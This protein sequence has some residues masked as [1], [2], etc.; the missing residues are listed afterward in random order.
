MPSYYIRDGEGNLQ[1]VESE[2]LAS[3]Q[4]LPQSV[5]S[6]ATGNPLFTSTNPGNVNPLSPIPDSRLAA[7]DQITTSDV[8]SSTALGQNGQ[9]FVTG[10]PTSGSVAAMPLDGQSSVRVQIAGTWIGTLQFEVS[11]DGGLS[12]V[13][14]HGQVVGTLKLALSV[15]ANGQFLVPVAGAGNIRVRATGFSSGVASVLL[16]LTSGDSIVAIA[17]PLVAA[18]VEGVKATYFVPFSFAP[19]ASATDVLVLQGSA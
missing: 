6:D 19:A 8:G 15:T 4:I 18:E 11:G 5:P 1:Q 7:A 14:V 2:Q 9:S 13:P 17:S 10:S 3:G 16:S 12:W